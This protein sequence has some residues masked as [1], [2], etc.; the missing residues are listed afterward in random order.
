MEIVITFLVFFILA[1]I[2]CIAALQLSNA[3]DKF[4]KYSKLP[5]IIIGAILAI[6]TSLPELA[7]SL[8]S[9]IVLNEP[10]TSISNPIGSNMFNIVILALL[11]IIFYKNTINYYLDK[12]NN[13]FN[14][15]A[16]IMYVSTIIVALNPA[17]GLLSVGHINVLSILIFVLYIVGITIT[18][19]SSEEEH[20]N[21]P[22]E[23]KKAMLKFAIFSVVV[24][25]SSYFLS[26]VADKI[27]ALTGLNSGFVGAVFLGVA[28][29]LP[30]L[31]SS[32][33]LVKQGNYNIAASN[34][35]GSNIFNFLIVCINDLFY[36]KPI[37]SMMD[38][39]VM[40]L[41]GY[42]LLLSIITFIMIQFKTKN[43]LLN[44]ILPILCIVIY[45]IYMITNAA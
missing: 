45:V 13:I 18:K 43:K 32:L 1:T 40:Q 42:G 37:W 5:P 14:I 16:I 12:K 21:N 2:T 8:T 3:C 35:I 30:E 7:T 34:I 44:I 23:L 27:I 26:L 15:I 29:S 31:V 6:A 39:G 9:S 20:E 19:S 25:I 10:T 24:L 11:N 28:T 33:N 41:L 4:E 38:A 22:S 36:T 17:L